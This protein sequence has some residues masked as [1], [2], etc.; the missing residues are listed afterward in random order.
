MEMKVKLNDVI[1][2]LDFVN[3]I[4]ECSTIDSPSIKAGM[5]FKNDKRIFKEFS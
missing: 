4:K 2:A 1:E 3:R 5:E